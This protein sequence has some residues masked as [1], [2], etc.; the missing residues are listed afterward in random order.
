MNLLKQF[1]DKLADELGDTAA[2]I[3]ANSV[4]YCDSQVKEAIKQLVKNHA[5]QFL[6]PAVK[7]HVIPTDPNEPLV[8][9]SNHNDTPFKVEVKNLGGVWEEIQ[10]QRK[11]DDAIFNKAEVRVEWSLKF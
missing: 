3:A 11:I 8:F 6:G 1:R 10:K 9:R 2:N 7:E 4:V 5:N